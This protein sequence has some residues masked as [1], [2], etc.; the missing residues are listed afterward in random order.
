MAGRNPKEALMPGSMEDRCFDYAR[1]F[2]DFGNYLV[3]FGVVQMLAFLYA[4]ADADLVNK[5][6]DS[7]GWMV[8]AVIGSTLFFRAL[9]LEMPRRG[10]QAA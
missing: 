4:L 8:G 7:P 10:E 1:R 9:G 2:W 3:G 5:V 6:K